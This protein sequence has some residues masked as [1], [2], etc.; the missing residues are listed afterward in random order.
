MANDN[1][2]L[3]QNQIS[4]NDFLAYHRNFMKETPLHW[5]NF[6]EIELVLNGSAE[7][8]HNGIVSSIKKGHVS[9]FRINDYHAIKNVCDL[10]V[11]SLSIKDSAISE[12][13]LTQ[14]NSSRN[15]LSFDL[16]DETFKTV[17]FFCEACINENSLHNRNEYYIKNLLECILILLLRLDTSEAKPIKKQHN[18]QLNNAIAYLHNH[19]RENP[20]LSTIAE[21]AHY[22]ST[23]FSHVFRKKIGRSFNDYLNE[24][25]VAYAKQL[26]N[27]TNL[28]VIDIGYQSGFNSYNNFYATFKQYTNLSPAEYKKKKLTN[29]HSLG[30]SWRFGIIDTDINT[31]PAYVYIKTCL[32]MH[33]NE[34]YF[35]YYYSYDYAIILDSIV[36]M[37]NGGVITPYNI[38][39]TDLKDKKR[40]HKVEFFF[41]TTSKACYEI[42]LKMG[43]GLNNVN[44]DFRHTTLSN[45][46][47][48]EMNNKKNKNNLAQEFTHAGGQV[49]WSSNSDAYDVHI[50]R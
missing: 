3:Y 46:T 17:L 22:S 36:N 10:E 8:I 38:K 33:D 42:T 32:L 20:S 14:L 23:H 37:E 40:T 15:N 7:H 45:L 19:F 34:Y 44:C 41:R 11:L 35:S 24:L 5:H 28:K 21:I 49:T 43:K 16:N 1:V 9:V 29:I 39:T 13:T 6:I 30:Y 4:E 2:F 31:D 12:R 50:D 18:S 25:K 26:L 27:T 47:L 48:Y